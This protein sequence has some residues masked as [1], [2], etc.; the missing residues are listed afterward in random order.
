MFYIKKISYLFQI[1]AASRDFGEIVLVINYVN[2]ILVQRPN[3][4]FIFL[5]N[6]ANFIIY[7]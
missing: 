6:Y 4:I 3:F 5:K 1:S 2:Y 7:K